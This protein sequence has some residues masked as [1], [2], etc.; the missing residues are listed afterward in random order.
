V[1]TL[2]INVYSADKQFHPLKQ[3][4]EQELQDELNVLQQEAR[5]HEAPVVTRLTFEGIHLFMQEKGS[6]GQWRWIL[7]SALLSL[8]ISRGR[9]SRI[10]AQVQLSSEFLWSCEGYVQTE[11]IP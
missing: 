8:A 2:V 4:L 3:E 5:D 9:L 7:R 1:D 10:I 6:R 11:Q